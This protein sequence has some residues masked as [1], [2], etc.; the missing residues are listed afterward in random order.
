MADATSLQRYTM[1]RAL[2]GTIV[3]LFNTGGEWVRWSDVEA[4]L[5]RRAALPSVGGSPDAA[6][7]PQR[8]DDEYR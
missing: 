3:P 2:N 4:L 7:T 8:H 5:S 1:G 6:L